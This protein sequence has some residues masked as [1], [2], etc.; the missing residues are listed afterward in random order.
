MTIEFSALRLKNEENALKL[1]LMARQE[2]AHKK[3]KA[4]CGLAV[5]AHNDTP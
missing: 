1:F 3:L 4:L 2:A 5:L